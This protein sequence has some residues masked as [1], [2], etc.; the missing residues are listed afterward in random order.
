MPQATRELQEK[1]D[2]DKQMDA[3][4]YDHLRS[5]DFQLSTGMIIAPPGYTPTDEDYSAIDYLCQE[6]DYGWDGP[7]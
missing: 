2:H 7:R 1:W 3:K 6:W 4:A 5:K